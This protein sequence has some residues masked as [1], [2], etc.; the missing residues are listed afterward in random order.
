VSYQGTTRIT[1]LRRLRGVSN[2]AD[3][4]FP[5]KDSHAFLLPRRPSSANQ[6]G[7][8]GQRI[9]SAAGQ[10]L[11]LMNIAQTPRHR[12]CLASLTCASNPPLRCHLFLDGELPLAALQG[13]HCFCAKRRVSQVPGPPATQN[14]RRSIGLAWIPRKGLPLNTRSRQRPYRRHNSQIR[15]K[16]NFI[17]NSQVLKPCGRGPRQDGLFQY[18]SAVEFRQ[19]PGEEGTEFSSGRL[20]SETISAF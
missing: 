17:P 16:T 12:R 2:T 15:E 14:F 19:S 6:P 13:I 10:R 20:A 1:P 18:A 3:R 4:A 7:L 8:W 9:R 11:P 5:A